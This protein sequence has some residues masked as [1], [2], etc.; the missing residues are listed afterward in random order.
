MRLVTRLAAAA[1]SGAIVLGVPASAVAQEAEAP[2]REAGG[3][4]MAEAKARA[5]Q[6]IE[7]RVAALDGALARLADAAA[8]SDGH[9]ATLTA[10]LEQVKAGLTALSGE[11]ASE[12]DPG[13][14][15]LLV[16]SIVEDFY[17]FRFQLPRVR[18]VMASDRAL[19]VAD[20]LDGVASRL[21]ALIERR[22]AAGQDVGEAEARLRDLR[23]HVTTGRNQARS[24]GDTAVALEV[25]G[26]PGN[27]TV[28]DNARDSLRAARGDLA[29]A[30]RDAAAIVASLRA[31][32]AGRDGGAGGAG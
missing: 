30:R 17:V 29:A 7:R 25:E 28:L 15:R 21:E 10:D 3:T 22:E 6:A 19:A 14:L 12:T 9:R 18:L 5:Q 32:R 8:V 11:I 27:A 23:Q 1:L 4:R 13:A 24:A 26:F 31:G 2:T 16:R 20:R